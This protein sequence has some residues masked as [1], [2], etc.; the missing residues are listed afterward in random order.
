MYHTQEIKIVHLHPILENP[1]QVL[2]GENWNATMYSARRA[3]GWVSVFYFVSLIVFGMMIVMSL[4][5]AI[6]LSHFSTPE[7]D[8]ADV[9]KEE[10]QQQQQWAQ[11]GHRGIIGAN[12]VRHAEEQDRRRKR[13][14]VHTGD[15]GH[16]PGDG[17]DRKISNTA[18]LEES[19][20][21][22][23]LCSEDDEEDDSPATAASRALSRA[24]SAASAAP[25]NSVG[26]GRSDSSDD[27]NYDNGREKAPYAQQQQ[28][29]EQQQTPTNIGVAT[30][31]KE[32][33]AGTAGAV[34]AAT[35]SGAKR[36]ASAGLPGHASAK[37][38]E[39]WYGTVRSVKVPEHMYPGFALCCLSAKNPL[40]RGCAAIVSN[41]GFDRF[42]TLLI[43]VS[44][45]VVAIDNP[46]R[47]PDSTAGR[48]LA[49]VELV[50]T[51]LFTVEFLLKVCASGFYF[52]PLAY[53]RDPWNV[54]D[55]V[56]VLVSVS[57][58]FSGSGPRLAGLRS[59]RAF[60][61]LRPLR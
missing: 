6:L 48:A 49:A 46:L 16:H 8:G 14:G 20:G 18:Q 27:D 25:W 55:F 39:V 9:A 42:I 61:A 45:I 33:V 10:E 1:N 30:A 59:L 54:L 11:Q 31:R 40:R 34:D 2:S 44:S 13:E 7:Q 38:A 36:M 52:M 51:I 4:F 41:P 22:W 24:H 15:G 57:Q 53:L 21:E 3:V 50:T 29:Q 28:L 58:L 60:R 17:D 37:L 32:G 5:L 56:V 35:N 26:S 19:G 47:D 43:V 23:E 12:R